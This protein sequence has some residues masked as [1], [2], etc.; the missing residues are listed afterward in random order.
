MRRLPRPTVTGAQALELCVSSI[1]DK[2]LTERL[3]LVSDVI[4]KAESVYIARG[5]AAALYRIKGTKTVA[6]RVKT[7]EME[8]VNSGLLVKAFR[9]GTFTMP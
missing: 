6:R 3:E 5:E 9:P 2:Q 8:R 7:A 4:D 1:Q